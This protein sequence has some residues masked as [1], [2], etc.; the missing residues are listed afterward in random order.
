MIQKEKALVDF[1]RKFKNVYNSEGG[2]RKQRT[3]RKQRNQ[4]KTKRSRR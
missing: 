3:H 1:M 4:R 2:R